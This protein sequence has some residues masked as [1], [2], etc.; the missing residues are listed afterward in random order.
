MFPQ[1]KA[2]PLLDLDKLQPPSSAKPHTA[3]N[4]DLKQRLK[5]F[6]RDAQENRCPNAD[7]KPEWPLLPRPTA[8][9]ITL[10]SQLEGLLQTASAELTTALASVSGSLAQP[11]EMPTGLLPL[12]RQ[13]SRVAI[14]SVSKQTKTKTRLQAQ[15]SS[16]K[17]HIS[18]GKFDEPLELDDEL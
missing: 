7:Q 18:C 14:D 8:A 17:E 16:L 6:K 13:L 9:K 15:I 2:I 10:Y 4:Q 11:I 12:I 1:N 3:T 5:L